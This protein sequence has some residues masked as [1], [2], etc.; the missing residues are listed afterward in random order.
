MTNHLRT[1]LETLLNALTP[2][3]IMGHSVT[4]L[5]PKLADAFINAVKALNETPPL[6]DADAALDM[7]LIAATEPLGWQ[8]AQHHLDFAREAIR[9]Y[10][11]LRPK[12][13]DDRAYCIGCGTY[14]K[15]PYT[16]ATCSAADEH[17]GHQEHVSDWPKGLYA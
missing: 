15:G 16:C 17:E 6:P 12:D 8:P 9:Q 4:S 5:D 7:A 13:E 1:P 10:V 11:A 3:T 14:P 2:L